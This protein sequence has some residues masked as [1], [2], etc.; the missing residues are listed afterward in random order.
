MASHTRQQFLC[1]YIA[2]LVVMAVGLILGPTISP[3]GS[4]TSSGIQYPQLVVRAGSSGVIYVLWS[5][6]CKGV[7]CFRL[8]RS[9]DGGQTFRQVATPPINTGSTNADSA[10]GSLDQL[11]FANAEDGYATENFWG[12]RSTLYATF[13]GGRTWHQVQIKG[14]QV[15]QSLTSS[16]TSFYA[17][18]AT[19]DA[20]H[21]QCTNW[22]LSS[23]TLN[24]AKWA[25]TA[26][27]ANVL[28]DAMAPGLG[29]ELA[30][31]GA[32]T[33]IVSQSKRGLQQLARSTNGGRSFVVRSE[34]ALD[35][36][37]ICQL[38]PTSELSLWATCA[39]GMQLSELLHSADGGEHWTESAFRT[40]DPAAF[41]S[42]DPVSSD[43]AY[44]TEGADTPNVQS[45]YRVLANSNRMSVVGHLPTR[46]NT[47]YSLMFVNARQ[48]VAYAFEGQGATQ[49]IW[50]TND[51]G[52]SWRQVGAP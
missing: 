43:V 19:C 24:T 32:A 42:F 39:Q 47:F 14:A 40:P 37:G 16:R 1:R 3:A 25:S 35:G 49:P 4:A 33:W 10:T 52:R 22:K 38:V 31:Y 18:T 30:A 28:R 11:V 6:S 46:N 15:I 36:A 48:G 9:S 41:G 12:K 13:N 8:M 34:R 2:F 27:P 50:S 5:G 26:L 21:S 29:L 51:G 17:I 23:S 20:G 7:R 45:I 44:A